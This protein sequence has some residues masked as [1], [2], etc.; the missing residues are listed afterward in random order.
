MDPL[1]FLPEGFLF[2]TY[3]TPSPARSS[4]LAAH[5]LSQAVGPSAPVPLPAHLLDCTLLEGRDGV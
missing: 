3:H 4:S 1:F 5:P 2:R